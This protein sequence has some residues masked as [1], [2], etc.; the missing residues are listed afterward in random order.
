MSTDES[1]NRMQP[2][3]PAAELVADVLEPALEQLAALIEDEPRVRGLRIAAFMPTSTGEVTGWHLDGAATGTRPQTG[4]DRAGV[5][6]LADEDLR[7][8]RGHGA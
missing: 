2:R 7:I 3:R 6:A 8:L 5:R 4:L 1:E